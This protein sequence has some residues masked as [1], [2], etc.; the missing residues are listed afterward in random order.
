MDTPQ[1]GNFLSGLEEIAIRAGREIMDIYD[2]GPS[3]PCLKADGS[4]VTEADRRAERIIL[5]GLSR[6]APGVAVVAEEEVAAGRIPEVNDRFLLVDPLDG[7]REFLSRNGQFTVNIALI[8]KGR[9]LAGVVYAPASGLLFAGGAGEAFR[10]EVEDGRILRRRTIRVRPA[11]SRVVV[12]VSRSH[13]SGEETGLQG[14]AI[15][16][17]EAVGSS[18]KFCLL[19]AGEADLYPRLGPTMEWDTAAGHAVLEA[20]GGAVVDRQGRA[21]RYGKRGEE[22]QPAFANGAFWAAG[23]SRILGSVVEGMGPSAG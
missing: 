15:E 4:P 13:A 16:H 20:A 18:L 5:D 6:L 7:T 11:P 1:T 23:D 3:A 9:P 10:A 19:A 12:L 14:L 21:L 2:R 22:G 17:F 8:E